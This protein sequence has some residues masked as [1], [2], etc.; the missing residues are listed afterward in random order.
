MSQAFFGTIGDGVSHWFEVIKTAF[1]SALDLF[2]IRATEGGAITG[3]SDIGTFLA[4]AIGVG[5]F[6]FALSFIIRLIRAK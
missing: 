4:W 1:E 5:V 3:L 6:G 2:V